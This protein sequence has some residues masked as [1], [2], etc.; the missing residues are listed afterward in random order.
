MSLLSS[1]GVPLKFVLRYSW[2]NQLELF[3]L[4]VWE[5]GVVRLVKN[6]TEGR[7]IY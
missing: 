6:D 2:I 7:R 4:L 3:E 5:V 1:V